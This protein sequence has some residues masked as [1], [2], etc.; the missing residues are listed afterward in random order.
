MTI[1]RRGLLGTAAAATTLPVLRARAAGTPTLKIG[2]LNDQSGPYKDI[3]GLGS[4]ACV[5]QAIQDFGP[6]GFNVEVVTADHQNKPDIGAGIARQWIDRDG[7]TLIDVRQHLLGGAGGE[8]RLPRE[9]RRLSQHR[10]GDRRS[11]RQPVHAGDA[12]L[13]V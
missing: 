2:V 1:T 11:H 7:V 9:E 3:Q 8:Q 5:K 6:K 13:V 4:V 10:G 12:A